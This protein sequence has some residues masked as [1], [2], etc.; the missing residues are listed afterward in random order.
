M[1][2]RSARSTST[3]SAAE[4]SEQP[5]DTRADPSFELARNSIG[6]LRNVSQP[7]AVA[8]PTAGTAVMAG[9]M[10]AVTGT[11]GPV[12]F[13][14]GI[15]AGA[16][17]VHVF[18]AL[19]RRFE[20]AGGTYF[21]AG[22]IIG[23]RAA[24]VVGFLYAASLVV[25][26]SGISVN[27]ATFAQSATLSVT[28]AD[29][30]WPVFAAI[31]A[32]TA[33]ATA[34]SHVKR[35]TS[36][37][38]AVELLGF[39]ALISLGIWILGT[40]AGSGVNIFDAFSLGGI[41]P[42]QVFFGIVVAFSSFGGFE[43]GLL[44][45]EETKDNRK[46]IPRGMWTALLVSGATYTFASWF[47]Y[48]GFGSVEG[49]AGSPEPLMDLAHQ[50]FGGP[51][52]IVMT[53]LVML[54]GTAAISACMG[55]GA[56]V[57]FAMVRDGLGRRQWAQVAL[58]THSPVRLVVFCGVVSAAIWITFALAG[59]PS[60]DAFT[61]ILTTGG[62]LQ[63]IIYVIISAASIVWFLRLR[64]TTNAV[65]AALAFAITGYT[66]YATVFSGQ[67]GPMAY[68]PWVAAAYLVLVM[69]V[70]FGFPNMVETVR[71]S[72]YWRTA[73]EQKAE[74]LEGGRKETTSQELV[75]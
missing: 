59:V 20:S 33:A 40:S 48:V 2:Q 52:A 38:T 60:P 51:A 8:G 25:A 28:G 26:S 3:G 6:F 30:P 64:E 74:I 37:I 50:H 62:L 69:A 9:V 54:A 65:V 61:Y 58:R 44:L 15:A 39:A 57:L 49:L 45:S 21:L 17:L 55:G 43:A 12:S 42:S 5:L 10:A 72:P 11:P 13:L 46:V 41:E 18:V 14:A 34:I 16:L 4:R 53:C 31:A 32:V 73:V 66:L 47:Q 67:E 24:I 23:I 68:L 56:R 63:M 22:V 71:S 70:I 7:I 29:V 35:F 19:A 1:A 27:V 75:G 36:I